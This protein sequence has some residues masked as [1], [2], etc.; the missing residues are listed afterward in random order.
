MPCTA[1]V[2]IPHPCVAVSLY[3]REA[4]WLCLCVAMVVSVWGYVAVWLCLCGAM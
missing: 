3:L 1:G 2:T 4:V